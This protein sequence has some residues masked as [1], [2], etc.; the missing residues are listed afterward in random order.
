[1]K[2]YTHKQ[3]VNMCWWPQTSY[4][5]R[6]SFS[7]WNIVEQSGQTNTTTTLCY[8]SNSQ[9]PSLLHPVWSS[10]FLSWLWYHTE[11]MKRTVQITGEF[12]FSTSKP[13]WSVWT[14]WRR[15]KYIVNCFSNI[16]LIFDIKENEWTYNRQLIYQQIYIMNV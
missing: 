3:L 4:I 15:R 7:N 16:I 11:R 12:I 8:D 9:L 13:F 6:L 2:G 10:R 1:M 5:Y 14:H